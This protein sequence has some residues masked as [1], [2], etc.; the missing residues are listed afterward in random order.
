[1]AHLIESHARAWV[2]TPFLHQGRK[3]QVGCDCIGLVIG[4][5]V[6]VGILFNGKSPLELDMRDYTMQPDGKRLLAALSRYLVPVEM[7]N[8]QAGDV[9]LMRF[10]REPQHVGILGGGENSSLTQARNLSLIHCYQGVGKVVE[11]RLD[12]KWQRRIVAVFKVPTHSF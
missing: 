8:M 12:E 1:M 3:K 2:G 9:A 5:L 11:H 4:V 7:K 10:E 6:E